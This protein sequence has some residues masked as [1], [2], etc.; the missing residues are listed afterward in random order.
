MSADSYGANG[1]NACGAE[2]ASECLG[3]WGVRLWAPGCAIAK[4]FILKIKLQHNF[5]GI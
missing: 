2:N 1:L 3:A 5:E 4:V